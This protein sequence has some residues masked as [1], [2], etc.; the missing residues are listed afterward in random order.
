MPFDNPLGWYALLSII[1]LI[2]LYLIRP[3]LKER[4]IPSLMFFIKDKGQKRHTNFFQKFINNLLLLLHM[5]LLIL[6]SLAILEPF[7]EIPGRLSADHTVLVIDVSASSQVVEN[8]KLRFDQII[9]EASDIVQG[10]T[11]ILLA[12]SV[13]LMVMEGG[14]SAEAK[15]T[16]N[17]LSPFDTP[18]NLGDAM[19]EARNLIEGESG[20]VIVLSDF[21]H[22]DGPDPLVAKRALNA[23]NIRVEFIEIGGEAENVGIVESDIAK[24]ETKVLVKNFNEENREVT[25]NLVQDGKIVDSKKATVFPDAVKSYSF[26]T[27]PGIS[28]IQIEEDDSLAIDDI[29]YLS[30]PQSLR[31]NVVLIT[32]EENS[33]VQLA[34]ESSPIIQLQVAQPPIVP[35]FNSADVVILHTV[36][37]TKILSSHYKDMNN[38]VK[39]GGSLVVVA[40]D[41]FNKFDVEN[42]PV[43]LRNKVAKGSSVVPAIENSLTQD[44]SFGRVNEYY[45]AAQEKDT[46][47]LARTEDG[48]PLLAVK[49]VTGKIFYYGIPD[50]GSDFKSYVD[51]P[52]FW[53]SLL[54][55][56]TESEDLTLINLPSGT[57]VPLLRQQVSTPGGVIETESLFLDRIGTYET[58]S[59]VIAS[60]LLNSDESNVAGAANIAAELDEFV[61]EET[62]TT[63][64]KRWEP[65]IILI[66]LGL[67]L[68]ELFFI[69]FR[70]DL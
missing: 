11:S 41:N 60:S 49:E 63:G 31:T 35:D 20:I 21:L 51:Y 2:L 57:L 67:L 30:T 58:E 8:G 36:D 55:F 69:K 44:T 12:S 3:K 18:T 70:G 34:L 26:E 66:I 19:L 56:L 59:S 6:L 7:S 27:L 48:N 52:V 54:S 50:E 29:L 45:E 16:L 32:N 28:K 40:Q 13:P 33:A 68:F 61:S 24:D 43:S 14:N 37:T 53:S 15:E 64:K 47:I 23:D 5:L 25:L 38:F 10:K 42:M 22:T 17:S 1:P 65:L 62:E 4:N 9:S 39:N 46:I